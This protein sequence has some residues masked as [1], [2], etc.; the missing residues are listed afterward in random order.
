M[1]MENGI[2]TRILL[3]DDHAILRKGLQL[4]LG[5]QDDFTI[6]G[7]AEEGEAGIA[8]IGEVLPDIVLMDISMPGLNGIEATKRITADYPDT[9]VIALS[10]HSE[11]KFVED[12][13]RAGAAG[14]ILKESV[15]EDL[16]RG[17]REVMNGAHYLSPSITG[18]VLSGY[19]E[20][21]SPDQ[22]LHQTGREIIETK[23]HAPPLPEN[24]IHRQRLVDNLEKNSELPLQT[25]TAPA[26]YG[27]STL[28]SCWLVNHETPHSWIS[29]DE[30]DND[31]LQFSTY[32]VHALVGLFP[33]AMSKT[34]QLLEAGNFP[35]VQVL[36]TTLINEINQ[37]EQN[38]ILV[39][40][41]YHC[42]TEKNVSDLLT[43][44]L[45]HPPKSMHL[46]IVGRMEP[47]LP[48]GKLRG[49]GLL[50]E[51][52]L[53]DLRFTEEE[54]ADYL[55]RTLKLNF[56]ESGVHTL[57][58]KTE[59]WITGIRLAA[60]SI[61]HRDDTNSLIEEL[62][63]SGQYVMDY[64]FHEVLS[65]QAENVRRH[66][67]YASIFHRFC[68]SLLTAVFDSHHKEDEALGWE[69]IDWLKKNQLFLIPL[70][71]DGYWYR[72][73]HLFQELLEK[74]L[75][76]HYAFDEI[77]TLHIKASV[78][79]GE[80]NLIEEAIRHTLAAGD[81]DAAVRLVE[82]NRQDFQNNDQWYVLEKWLSLFPENVI[83]QYPELLVVRIW[84][85]YHHFDVPAIP[86]VIDVIERQ[87]VNNTVKQ[88]LLGEVNFFKGYIHYFQ[89]DGSRSL[90]YLQH[91]LDTVPT[92]NKEVRGQAE[93]LYGLA[94]QMLGKTDEAMSR[95]HDVLALSHADVSAA[96]TR[97]LVA[98][99]YIHIISGNLSEAGMA[100]EQLYD[101][102]KSNKYL[103]AELWSVY[104]HGLISFYQNDI[105][106]AVSYFRKAVE[107][108]Y[109]LHTRATVDSLVGLILSYQAKGEQ[110]MA[111]ATTQ[112]LLDYVTLLKDPVYK[113]IAHLS[114]IRVSIQQGLLQ[115]GGTWR[116]QIPS[117]AENMVWWLEIP[118]VSY[119]RA[120]LADGTQFNLEEAAARLQEIIQQNEDNHNI[121]QIIQ[122][123]PILALVHKK[124]G[125]PE[126]ALEILRGAIEL[127]EAGGW[128]QPFVELGTPMKQLLLELQKKN[129]SP[130]LEGLI[131]SF[132]SESQNPASKDSGAHGSTPLHPDATSGVESLT[133]REHEIL[134]LLVQGLANKEIAEKLFVSIDT[135]KTHLRNIYFKLDVKSRL[136]AVAKAKESNF[137]SNTNQ[138][139]EQ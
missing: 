52:R 38:F 22:S 48:L 83:Q 122:V 28:V 97:L 39:I 135:V 86:A 126:E 62:E 134:E 61:L 25:V 12:M 76:R 75:Q 9:K 118:R 102:S 105:D 30:R 53:Q 57:N 106:Q 60:L 72:F 88:A 64:L 111:H 125:N 18:L 36:A 71:N 14:Y 45:R 70:D 66:I 10:I 79:F 89:N 95:L 11:K 49:Q 42:I 96:K 87:A 82:Q 116:Q 69:I 20:A 2:K 108:K 47:F 46:V 130:F 104:L 113:T 3:I 129:P 51:I 138:D 109:V 99:V 136:Q 55:Q 101:F 32:L 21:L 26:G 50:S 23:L 1:A 29:L 7:E 67:V 33:G 24:H 77:S 123:M 121:C 107:N 44:L 78:W 92:A 84:T 5:R 41:D 35:P 43:E 58:D 40:D 74:Q 137:R 91:A 31:L 120:L 133:S 119:C 56:D 27:K 115:S 73:H 34:L 94:S 8:L 139:I 37:I 4:L 124:L 6:V 131:T 68:G 112:E 13:L 15:P 128:V 17:I 103:Y 114:Q 98:P 65:S 127:A 59:G 90:Q 63:K 117:A 54:T 81:L 19:R 93:I 16:V 132:R 110:D 100:N 85:L 80:Q